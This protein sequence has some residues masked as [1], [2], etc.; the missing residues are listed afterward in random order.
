MVQNNKTT[1]GNSL[2]VRSHHNPSPS[3]C[4]FKI[5]C[6]TPHLAPWWFGAIYDS[7]LSGPR[8]VKTPTNFHKKIILPIRKKC[9]FLDLTLAYVFRGL[10]IGQVLT[11]EFC[12][13]VVAILIIPQFQGSKNQHYRLL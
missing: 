10:G 7:V 12:G 11:Q 8:S 13:V 6:D 5:V 4:K 1:C 2:M 9:T 3:H